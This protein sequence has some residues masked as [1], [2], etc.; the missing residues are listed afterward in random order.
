MP[1]EATGVTPDQLRKIGHGAMVMARLAAITRESREPELEHLKQVQAVC[2]EG[3]D[4]NKAWVDHRELLVKGAGS[5][6]PEPIRR[7]CLACMASLSDADECR[8][9][10]WLTC[11]EVLVAAATEGEPESLR[12]PAL[13][14]LV[15][16]SNDVEVRQA[17]WSA[18]ETR[19]LLLGCLA[20]GQPQEVRMLAAWALRRGHALRQTG[21]ATRTL[22]PHASSAPRAGRILAGGGRW[23]RAYRESRPRLHP[24]C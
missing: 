13:W 16:L 18:A 23:A 22:G 8:A 19:G 17:L 6:W 24:R 11:R 15:H 20:T 2:L 12:R 3:N 7:T 1:T 9:A 10:I 14:S 21:G 5:S 4:K